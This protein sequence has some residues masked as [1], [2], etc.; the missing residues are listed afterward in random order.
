MRKI[1][2]DAHS[3]RHDEA[4]SGKVLI[5]GSDIAEM[6]DGQLT[7]IRRD[8]IGFVFQKFNLLPTLTARGNID[9]A[10]YLHGTAKVHDEHLAEI[11]QL[12]MIE[13]KMARKPSEFPAA[14][15]SA[16]P[17]RGHSRRNRRFC[18]RTSRQAV[19]I[20]GIPKLC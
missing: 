19:W 14:S 5:E 8:K 16:L 20:R 17:L 12:L 4:T 1:L 11:L 6:N 15:S 10:R 13:D 3:G 7:G 9:I 2:A 18:W